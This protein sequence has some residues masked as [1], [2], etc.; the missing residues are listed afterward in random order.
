MLFL[1]SAFTQAELFFMYLLIF[2]CEFI[3]GRT[4]SVRN[5]NI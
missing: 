5:E 2:C 4:Y 3:F 1:E